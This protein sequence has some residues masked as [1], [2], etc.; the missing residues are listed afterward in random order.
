MEGNDVVD[1]SL[2]S[3]AIIKRRKETYLM[4]LK[5]FQRKLLFVLAKS[6]EILALRSPFA[7]QREEIAG[8][9]LEKQ[10]HIISKVV[11]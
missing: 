6:R 7:N 9:Y 2:E 3:S 5:Y 4:M 10:N 1:T 11:E 8:V